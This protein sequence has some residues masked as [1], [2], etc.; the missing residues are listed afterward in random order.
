[1]LRRRSGGRLAGEKSLLTHEWDNVPID[2]L[3]RK[4]V[5]ELLK[6]RAEEVFMTEWK[7]QQMF[8]CVRDPGDR[9]KRYFGTVAETD[10]LDDR[11][12]TRIDNEC[13]ALFVSP[14][15]GKDSPPSPPSST[16]SEPPPEAD[17]SSL[18]P[19]TGMDARVP[20]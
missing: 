17:A 18:W 12:H 20:D 15:E 16:S 11:V 8:Y 7:R 2:E 6:R 1:M 13:T 9:R 10:D 14:T 3:V 19:R 5:H 4:A